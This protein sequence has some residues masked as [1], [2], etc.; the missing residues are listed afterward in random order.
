MTLPI[1]PSQAQ[2]MVV[3]PRV[4]TRRWDFHQ[5]LAGVVLVILLIFVVFAC[6]L[7]LLLW[8]R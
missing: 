7:A 1:G 8:L 6:I 3:E 5:M 4:S 2:A